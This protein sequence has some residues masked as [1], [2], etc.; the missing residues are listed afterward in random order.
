MAAKSAI[1]AA[2]LI[3]LIG[4]VV[5]IGAV[6]ALTSVRRRRCWRRGCRR[7]HTGEMGYPNLRPYPPRPFPTI[8]CLQDAGSPFP[9][10]YKLAW[11][12]M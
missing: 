9:A 6:A 7:T 1:I 10:A 2:W 4:G 3:T 12:A 8:A 11:T 5:L